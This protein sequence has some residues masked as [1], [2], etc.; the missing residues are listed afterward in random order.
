MMQAKEYFIKTIS[1]IP[2]EID[3]Q[4]SWSMEISDHI[5][6]ILKQRD[7]TQRQFAIM[8]GRSEAEVSRWL[9]GRH[10]FTLATLAKI[11]TLLRV[12]LISTQ[13]SHQS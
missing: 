11:S 1:Q 2:P 10:N 12:D 3:K 4:V 5:S 6:D 9:A 13:N 7:M 8:M